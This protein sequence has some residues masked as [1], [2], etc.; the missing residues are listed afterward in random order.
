[1][2]HEANCFC[3]LGSSQL[4]CSFVLKAQQLTRCS[5]LALV[6]LYPHPG[7]SGRKPHLC[8]HT[9]RLRGL[10]SFIYCLQTLFNLHLD[11]LRNTMW[12][13]R[14]CQTLHHWPRGA[15]VSIKAVFRAQR[16]SLAS[17]HHP[18]PDFRANANLGAQTH[19]PGGHW[20]FLGCPSPCTHILSQTEHW[21]WGL[22][23]NSWLCILSASG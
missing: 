15:A 3:H 21:A 20:W 12:S 10:P 8:S 1:M 22:P 14:S 18:E 13:H 4:Y 9:C 17:G 6:R 23:G 16:T 5:K 7:C 11:L 19:D 2:S